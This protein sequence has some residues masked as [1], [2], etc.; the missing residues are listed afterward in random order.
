MMEKQILTQTTQF[1]R[2]ANR[3]KGDAKECEYGLSWGETAGLEKKTVNKKKKGT[4]NR[5]I[6]SQWNISWKV[7][8][9]GL[10]GGN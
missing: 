5:G 3:W 2:R 1:A 6:Q 4:N 10:G 8:E 9:T 7:K